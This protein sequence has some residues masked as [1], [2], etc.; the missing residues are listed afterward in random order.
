MQLEPH[1]LGLLHIALLAAQV[2]E[3][4][5]WLHDTAALPALT[6]LAHL[7][8]APTA[9]AAGGVGNKNNNSG[10]GGSGGGPSPLMSFTRVSLQLPP[11][12]PAATAGASTN[13]LYRPAAAEM[14]PVPVAGLPE[15]AG[16]YAGGAAGGDATSAVVWSPLHRQWCTL[17]SFSGALI[18][19]MGLHLDVSA[20]MRGGLID[21]LIGCLVSLMLCAQCIGKHRRLSASPVPNVSPVV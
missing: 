2:A 5:A 7:L 15:T 16:A 8:L 12:T 1:S 4:A 3:G 13:I 17:L 14:L 19:A 11:A 10:G 9:A 6:Q 20:S 21:C 18:R